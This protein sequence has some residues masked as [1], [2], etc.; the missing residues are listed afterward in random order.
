[1]RA[2]FIHSHK[3]GV[4]FPRFQR[5][6]IALIAATLLSGISAPTAKAVGLPDGTYNCLTGLASA[7]TPTFTITSE[8]VSRGDLV[9]VQ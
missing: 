7:V 6:L 9:L 8:V 3:V 4:S 2:L 1:M 5:I